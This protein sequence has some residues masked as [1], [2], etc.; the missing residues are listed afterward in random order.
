[1]LKICVSN[2]CRSSST[3][4]SKTLETLPADE[5]KITRLEHLQAGYFSCFLD[6][7]GALVGNCLLA[8]VKK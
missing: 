5:A 4:N 6:A 7:V 1:M 8:I 3:K 2:N